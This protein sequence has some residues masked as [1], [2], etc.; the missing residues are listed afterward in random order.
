MTDTATRQGDPALLGD[1]VAQELLHSRYPA[2]LAYSWTDGTPR[3]VPI[4]FHWTG[5]EL[6]MATWA[7]GP[8]ISY[9]ARRIEHLRADPRV[10]VSVDTEDNPPLALLLRGRVTVAVV[11]GIVPEYAEAAARYLGPEAAEGYLGQF[12]PGSVAMARIALRPTWVGL[13]DFAERLPGPLG[14]VH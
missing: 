14:G 1:P 13:L 7:A 5:E 10:A 3:V 12:P 8:H 4:W 2:H 6:V 9:P 11:D